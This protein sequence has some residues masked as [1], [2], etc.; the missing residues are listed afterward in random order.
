MG[1]LAFNITMAFVGAHPALFRQ[2]ENVAT[3]GRGKLLREPLRVA[4]FFQRVPLC[5]AMISRV[6]DH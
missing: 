1:E 4:G 3:G 6:G 2:C 5:E